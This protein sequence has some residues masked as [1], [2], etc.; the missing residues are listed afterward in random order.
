[1]DRIEA[2]VRFTLQ[3]PEAG[4]GR[5]AVPTLHGSQAE[6]SPNALESFDDP[7]CSRVARDPRSARDRVED[8]VHAGLEASAIADPG[9]DAD[10]G[11]AMVQIWSHGGNRR[12]NGFERGLEAHPSKQGP[13]ETELPRDVCEEPHFLGTL[14]AS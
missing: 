3:A 10:I 1:M 9:P 11:H 6:A 12:A 14:C 5:L 4:S 2:R 13:V 7:F 8:L